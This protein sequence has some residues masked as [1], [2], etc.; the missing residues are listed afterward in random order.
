MDLNVTEEK[1]ADISMTLPSPYHE[2]DVKTTHRNTTTVNFVKE[3][4][5][6]VALLT[7]HISRIFMITKI[8]NILTV[9]AYI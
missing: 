8:Q 3:T 7:R 1:V 9:K 6:M 2:G 4:S 5:V